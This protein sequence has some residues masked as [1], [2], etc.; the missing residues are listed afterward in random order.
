M[1][2]YKLMLYL[3]RRLIPFAYG[4]VAIRQEEEEDEEKTVKF[5]R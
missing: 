4:Y 1:H 5:L 2:I 3:R